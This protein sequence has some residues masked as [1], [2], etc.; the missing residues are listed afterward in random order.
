[1]M[2]VASYVATFLAGAIVM[3]AVYWTFDNWF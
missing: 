2:T 1:M 3:L